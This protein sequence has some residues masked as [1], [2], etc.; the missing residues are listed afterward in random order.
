M[1]PPSHPPGCKMQVPPCA[2][3]GRRLRVRGGGRPCIVHLGSCIWSGGWS[4]DD[5]LPQDQDLKGETRF[6][7]R[8]DQLLAIAKGVNRARRRRGFALI[9]FGCI[10]NRVRVTR[11]YVDGRHA[12]EDREAPAVRGRVKVPLMASNIEPLGQAASTCSGLTR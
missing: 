4:G 1:H 3:Q 6:L 5:L 9:D 2:S 10:P 7:R 11:V 12:G 8:I